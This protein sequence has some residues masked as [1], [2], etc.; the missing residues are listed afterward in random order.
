[1]YLVNVGM[2]RAQYKLIVVANVRYLEDQ[3]K[4]G[5]LFATDT[6]WLAQQDA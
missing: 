6:I 5:K 2:T 3:R 4:Q 1:M